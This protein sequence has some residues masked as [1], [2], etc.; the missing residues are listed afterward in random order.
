MSDGLDAIIDSAFYQ[1]NRQHA[2]LLFAQDLPVSVLEEVARLPG[3]RQV[4]GQQFQPVILRHGQHEKT[5]A[6]EAK[7]PGA[8][9][10]RV[11]LATGAVQTAPPGGILLSERLAGQLD[12]GVGDLV[13][14][15]FLAGR[16]ET[17]SLAVTG[18]VPLYFGLGAYVDLAFLNTLFR[19]EPRV[20]AA[21]VTLD[22]A[23]I[24]AL[25]AA[26][27]AMPGLTGTIMMTET[28]RTFQAT[29]R[30]NVTIMSTVYMVIAILIAVGVGYN[31]ARIQLSERSR[32]LASLRILGFGRAQVS[33]ILVGE[34]M[35]LALLAQP[36]GWGLGRTL[37][38]LMVASFSSDLYNLPLV[39]KPAT[40]AFASVVVLA[41]TL[42]SVL[43]VRRRLDRIDLAAALKTRE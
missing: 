19:Q 15:E 20:S 36:L 27:K 4:E 26:I 5:V 21:N 43:V 28:R 41:A 30:Q 23:E 6:I 16:R 12:L 42:V 22:P 13:E 8:D 25:H 14:V 2:T 17:H 31:S 3:V 33:Y 34:L 38:G 1:S 40:F 11:V 18:I 9:L 24:D 39:L 29:I 32:E 37:A 10:S 35:L 7:T